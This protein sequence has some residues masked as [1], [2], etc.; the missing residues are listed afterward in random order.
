MTV[1]GAEFMI[2]GS[3]RSHLQKAIVVG[4]ELATGVPCEMKIHPFVKQKMTGLLRRRP[5]EKLRA[6]MRR[7]IQ[8]DLN[9]K[10]GVKATAAMQQLLIELCT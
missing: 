3:I 7:L 10:S 2:L 5:L 1:R 4:Q 6:D 8:V 9:M